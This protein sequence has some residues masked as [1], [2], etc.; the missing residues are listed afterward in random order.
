MIKIFILLSQKCYIC[1]ID[2]LQIDHG[3]SPEIA[4]IYHIGKFPVIYH[5]K[6]GS[7]RFYDGELRKK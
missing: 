1:S 7:P 5:F 2:Y 4:R 6:K 3:K